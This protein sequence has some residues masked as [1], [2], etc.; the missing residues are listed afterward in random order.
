MGSVIFRC[1]LLEVSVQGWI[2]GETAASGTQDEF[3]SIKCA[4][5][6]RTHL[7]NPVN[8][9]VLGEKREQSKEN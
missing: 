3:V 7:V 1:P 9:K 4:A 8:G 5:C 2:A 6:S